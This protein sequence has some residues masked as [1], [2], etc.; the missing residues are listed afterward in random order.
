MLSMAMSPSSAEVK[1][2]MARLERECVASMNEG[3]LGQPITD[4]NLGRA[5]QSL[6]RDVIVDGT[7]WRMLVRGWH[8][9]ATGHLDVKFELVPKVPLVHIAIHVGSGGMGMPMLFPE[10]LVDWGGPWRE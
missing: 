10:D 1:A 4:A 2:A 5:L 8:L 6:E 3:M 7:P 9:T